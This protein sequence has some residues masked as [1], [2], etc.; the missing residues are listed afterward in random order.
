MTVLPNSETMQVSV[1][2]IRS[3]TCP[4]ENFRI[5]SSRNFGSGVTLDSVFIATMF[6]EVVIRLK[7]LPTDFWKFSVTQES[8]RI[9]GL[10]GFKYV[11]Q[12]PPPI[13]FFTHRID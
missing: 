9:P 3:S 4:G 13:F 2:G 12:P 8:R 10:L 7:F 1:A 5:A 6:R 11:S